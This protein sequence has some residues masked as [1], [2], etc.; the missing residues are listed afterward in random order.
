MDQ[1]GRTPIPGDRPEGADV[2]YEPE[3]E[4]LT[5][6]IA[7][8]ESPSAASAIDWNKVVQLSSGILEKRSKHLQ[9]ACYL[10]YGLLKTGEVQGFCLGMAIVRDLLEHFW[11]TLF[12]PVKRM[13]GR[14]ATLEWWEGKLSD[15]MSDLSPQTLK[16][17]TRDTLMDHLG[18]IDE[19]LG[20]HMDDPPLLLPLIRKTGDVLMEEAPVEAPTPAPPPEP[21]LTAAPEPR[22][23]QR[24]ESPAPDRKPAP[25]SV[26]NADLDPSALLEQGLLMAAKAASSLRNDNPAL[27]LPYRLNRIA[28]WSTLDELPPATG[29]KTMLPPPDEDIVTAL[30]GL[31]Q[32]GD[33]KALVD[34][35]ES[36]VRQFLFWLDL[37]RYSARGMEQMGHPEVSRVIE[38]ETTLF[39]R[40][41]KGVETLA[42]S[43][44][45]PFADSE[46]RTWLQEIRLFSSTNE[47]K[48][49]G[50]DSDG[51]IEQQLAETSDQAARLVREKKL[52]AALTLFQDHLSGTV[53]EK[54]RFLW[55][56]GLCQTLIDAQK[57]EIAS[58][59]MD[60]ILDCITRFRLDRWD[61]ETA[62]NAL[63]LVL[64]GLRIKDRETHEQQIA[65]VLKRIAMLDPVKALQ[66]I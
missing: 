54:E 9:A 49:L 18:F 30:A 6:E 14:K 66:M 35:S 45:T 44:G 40:K 55:K 36:R 48:S 38:M 25:T 2:R 34:S 47:A 63:E 13:K 5:Q 65:D 17:D 62:V 57:I 1:I 39:V 53:P 31:H 15:F 12:P 46:T 4:A 27:S 26:P 16:K 29:G 42:F 19:F 33:W 32:S 20:A 43:D 61:P 23:I 41:L 52:D 11:E 60:D 22:T 8:L 7:K 59:Y 51:D 64:K 24:A 10:H 28:A 3:F 50:A 56:L 58:P 21:V 37:S